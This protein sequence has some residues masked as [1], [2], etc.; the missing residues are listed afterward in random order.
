MSTHFTRETPC[1]QCGGRKFYR[2]SRR[3]VECKRNQDRRKREY[4]RR[5]GRIPP[6]SQKHREAWL[7]MAYVQYEDVE[8]PVL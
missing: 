2:K 1:E 3:C 8:R 6:R 5:F 7:G 4:E